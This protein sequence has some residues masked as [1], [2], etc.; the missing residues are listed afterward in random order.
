VKRLDE[1]VAERVRAV[2]LLRSGAAGR[3][4]GFAQRLDALARRHVEGLSLDQIIFSGTDGAMSLR[5]M[6]LGPNVVSEYLRS[7]AGDAALSG[8]RFDD[9]LI[10]LPGKRSPSTPQED[11]TPADDKPAP[12]GS[13]RFRAASKL[14]QQLSE[15][16]S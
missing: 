16:A 11:E 8:A 15:N 4:T 6:A 10:E 7:L 2:Q 14:L 13:I 12:A 9:F 3:T 1:R 5:G